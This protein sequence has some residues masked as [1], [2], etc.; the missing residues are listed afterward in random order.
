MVIGTGIEKET[1]TKY[2]KEWQMYIRFCNARGKKQVPGRDVR[3][4]IE[5]VEPYLR[6]RAQ[7]NNAN[8]IAQIKS[9]LKHC[10]IC[11]DHLLPTA[12]G[13]GPT[14]LRLQLAMIAK[15]IAK[16]KRKRK[17]R[18]GIPTG[19]KRA[20][21]LGQVG[22]GLLFSAYAATKRKG[23]SRLPV[24]VRHNLVISICMHTGCLRFKMVRELYKHARLRWS[25]P[26]RCFM[27]E[28]DW[29]KMRRPVGQYTIKFPQHPRYHA[30]Q[31]R[32]Y[33]VDG[34]STHYFTAEAVLRWHVA[35]TGSTQV[36]KLFTPVFGEEPSSRD[37]KKWLRASFG[38]LLVGTKTEVARLIQ[39]ITPH[40]F[41]AGM[42]GDL[43]RE[44]IPRSTIKKLGRWHSERAMEQ[45]MRDGLAQK[46]S[47]TQYRQIMSMGERVKVI[48]TKVVQ[49]IADNDD[50]EGYDESEEEDDSNG[51][52]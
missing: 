30:M 2:R 51:S 36:N 13:E 40:S 35:M 43:E 16:M 18:A 12:K 31:Y 29:N 45:Y 34:A 24:A 39:A 23:F 1:A 42:A 27:M 41:R 17:I 22:I 33:N 14:K 20:L 46:L 48:S 11:Y 5:T 4:S 47:S 37:F 25:Q 21:A 7:T 44:D 49:V 28:S 26:S 8:S 52:N 10:G 15:E 9:A 50:S 6:W 32:A 19:P 38:A 3:W